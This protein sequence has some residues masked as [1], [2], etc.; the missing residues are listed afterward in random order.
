MHSYR[1]IDMSAELIVESGVP[2]A[3]PVEV[4]SAPVSATGGA[5]GRCPEAR[6]PSESGLPGRHDVVRTPDNVDGIGR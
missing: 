2:V 1:V 6:R 3:G 4:E 5:I